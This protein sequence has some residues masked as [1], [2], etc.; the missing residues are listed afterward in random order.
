MPPAPQLWVRAL[1]A[2]QQARPSPRQP[3]TGMGE[4]ALL[5]APREEEAPRGK[6]ENT[7]PCRRCCGPT[8]PHCQPGGAWAPLCD[9]TCLLGKQGSR[10]WP[11]SSHL[12]V[13]G[14]QNLQNVTRETTVGPDSK[15]SPENQQV[16]GFV[17]HTH[18][19]TASGEHVAPSAHQPATSKGTGQAV[20]LKAIGRTCWPTTASPAP[21][22]DARWHLPR[23]ARCPLPAEQGP[24]RHVLSHRVWNRGTPGAHQRTETQKQ[25]W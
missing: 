23:C 7:F 4:R 24:F 9:G 16:D 15:A 5:Q 3:P 10:W 2:K 22:S 18:L 19:L 21:H 14:V 6:R 8:W 12:R 20:P 13:P 17:A 25:P 11:R 1:K